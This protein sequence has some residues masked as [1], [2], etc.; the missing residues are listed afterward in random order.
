MAGEAW[1]LNRSPYLPFASL[2]VIPRPSPWDAAVAELVDA[3]P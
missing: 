2:S 1:A 3:L